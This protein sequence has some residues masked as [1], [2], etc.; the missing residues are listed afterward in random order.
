[1]KNE[2]NDKNDNNAMILRLHDNN[3]IIWSNNKTTKIIE[4][5]IIKIDNE[6]GCGIVVT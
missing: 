1:M 6:N 3:E 4:I 2:L 5:K